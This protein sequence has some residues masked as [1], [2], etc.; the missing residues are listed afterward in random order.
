[1]IILGG[2][3][4]TIQYGNFDRLPLEKGPNIKNIN[5]R[6]LN[7]VIIDPWRNNPKSRKFTFNFNPHGRYL[8]IYFLCVKTTDT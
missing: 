3:F 6:V 5:I 8:R 7:N 2:D 1:M 4:S